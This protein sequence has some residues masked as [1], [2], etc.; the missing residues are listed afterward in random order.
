M[1]SFAP[2]VH[3]SVDFWRRSRAQLAAHFLT[4][5]HSDHTEGLGNSWRAGGGGAIYCSAATQQLL[6]VLGPAFHSV[7]FAATCGYALAD[8]PCL[9]A[10]SV[11]RH[12]DAAACLLRWSMIICVNFTVIKALS[13][14][15]K[16]ASGA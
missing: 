10:C 11:P 15:R 1:L 2:G 16:I 8:H 5:M 12:A 7:A 6:Q 4:H 9:L 3:V 13:I 14:K